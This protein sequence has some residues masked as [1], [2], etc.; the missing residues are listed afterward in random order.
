MKYKNKSIENFSLD[1]YRRIIENALLNDYE[2]MT[3]KN[4]LVSG[5]PKE[6]IFIMRHDFD[7]KPENCEIFFIAEKEFGVRS[8]TYVR[9][10][11]NDCNPFS[12]KNFAI[13]KNAEENG[14]EIGLHTNFVE[15]A[16][17]NHREAIE[18]LG[19]EWKALS[20][21][22]KISG[23]SCHR[24]F[25]Y[26]YNSLP[27]VYENWDKIANIGIEYHAYDKKFLEAVLILMKASI[28]I[29]VG[30]I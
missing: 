23:M 13:L 18:I 2:F 27:W 22:Y 3:V 14:F 7:K 29:Y 16:K 26:A 28:L 25:N 1:A 30:D 9:V 8:T 6:R 20:A 21:F 24:D 5:C 17:I 10:A 12:Y 11:N 15:F 19:S 4:F